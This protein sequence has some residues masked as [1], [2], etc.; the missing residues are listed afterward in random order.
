ME[1]VESAVINGVWNNV[2][3]HTSPR[4][5]RYCCKIKLRLRPGNEANTHPIP[6]TGPRP[7]NEP[8]THPIPL[9]GKSVDLHILY[10]HAGCN[11]GADKNDA[12]TYYN[13]KCII[14]ITYSIGSLAFFSSDVEVQYLT[15]TRVAAF[16]PHLL[17]SP[18]HSL[19]TFPDRLSNLYITLQ[20]TT[21]LPLDYQ[22]QSSCS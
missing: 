21:A 6:L 15:Y 17:P 11:F 18:L 4:Q 7:G 5:N 1:E 10:K 13:Q 14:S 19:P 22:R 16:A 12:A 9:I 3:P 20:R 8:N 2:V